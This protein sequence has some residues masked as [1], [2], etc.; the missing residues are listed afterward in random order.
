MNISSSVVEQRF[1]FTF[2]SLSLS[3]CAPSTSL[4]VILDKDQVDYKGGLTRSGFVCHNCRPLDVYG[5]RCANCSLCPVGFHSDDT[6]KMCP[7]GN[8]KYLKELDHG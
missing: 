3:E 1:Q 7:A 4:H 8:K 6:C 5:S 2:I